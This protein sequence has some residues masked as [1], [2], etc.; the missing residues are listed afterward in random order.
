M[1]RYVSG[2]WHPRFDAPV[3]RERRG[4]RFEAFVPDVLSG[5]S[6]RVSVGLVAVLGEA[7]AAV[8]ALNRSYAAE[9]PHP[10]DAFAYVLLRVEAT[11]SSRIEEIE[12]SPRR[13]LTAE[14]EHR[15]GGRSSDRRAVEV[16][17]NVEAM[18]DAVR[19][20]SGGMSLSTDDLLGVHRRLMA[21]SM[22]PGLGGWVRDVQNWI[23]GSGYTP[24]GAT[25]VP[26]PP[27]EVPALLEDLM[28]FVNRSDVPPLV[29]AGIAHAQ[30]ETIHPF[31]D[32]NGR[33]GRA[34]VHA[35]L[36]RRGVAPVFVPP[37]S[38]VLARSRHVYFDGLT[39]WRHVGAA[40]DPERDR[41][42]E[43]WLG[44]FAEATHSACQEAHSYL[45]AVSALETDLRDRAAPVRRGSSADLLLGML[46]ACPIFTVSSAARMIGRSA[47]ATGSAVNH[48]AKK[49]V[50]KQRTVG[51]ERYRVFEAPDVIRLISQLDRELSLQSP[52]ARDT[53]SPSGGRYRT[54]HD[55]SAE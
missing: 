54:Q 38:A 43:E 20:A 33:V 37:I 13:L 11:A 35:V 47:V 24:V 41:A 51:K 8:A 42:A 18:E 5:W 39:A 49:G 44:V 23:G 10:L 50:L 15:E 4:G 22:N 53:T 29:Q 48:L 19:L 7:E 46:P 2:Y 55:R 26:P 34:L 9:A 31:G 52:P 45:Q 6:P 25:F 36:R 14:A 3:T 40:D 1:G 16:L 30:F 28:A 32:G 17:A 21:A 12:L 27:E